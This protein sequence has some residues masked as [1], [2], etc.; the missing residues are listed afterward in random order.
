MEPNKPVLF[1]AYAIFLEIK[2]TIPMEA[3]R[4]AM[5]AWNQMIKVMLASKQMTIL[6]ACPKIN[7]NLVK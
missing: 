6:Y 5:N 4:S 2:L 1:Q 3:A 7:A